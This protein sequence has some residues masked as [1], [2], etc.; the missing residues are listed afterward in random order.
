LTHIQSTIAQT[1]GFRTKLKVKAFDVPQIV[2]TAYIAAD[3]VSAGEYL[4]QT[5]KLQLFS[6]NGTLYYYHNEEKLWIAGVSKQ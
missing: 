1:T 3:M 5:L 2:K 4:R 6:D